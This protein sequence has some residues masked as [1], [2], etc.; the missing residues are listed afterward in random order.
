MVVVGQYGSNPGG[1]L[2]SA[3]GPAFDVMVAQPSTYTSVT[4][5][6]C[7]LGG[8]TT[9]EWWTGTAWQAISP[10]PNYVP[11]NPPCVTF[12]LTVASTPTLAQLTG[13]VFSGVDLEA[14]AVAL[15]QLPANPTNKNR[16]SIG[17]VA[18]DPDD[19]NTPQ[20]FC[21]FDG[22]PFTACSSPASPTSA[23]TDGNHTFS[24]H[25][26]D[27]S[28]NQSSD[29]TYNWLIDTAQPVVSYGSHQLVY[30]VDQN[31][32]IPCSVSD[33]PPSSGIA[34]SS[35]AAIA[36]PAYTFHLGLNNFTASA[37][38]KA[39]NTGTAS[40]SFTVTVTPGSLCSLTKQFAEGSPQFA[41]LPPATRST[42][43]SLTTTMCNLLATI[44]F[45]PAFK[46]L[47]VAAYQVL[48]KKLASNGWLTPSQAQILLTLAAAL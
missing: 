11:G 28:G 38:D 48:A 22:G 18:S 6:D 14:P 13:T 45:S 3:A 34:T 26:V 44:Q 32:N 27:S 9:V 39:G 21:S 2:K 15:S 37:T 46:P 35:C 12:T 47:A 10:A 31:I 43:D 42:I 29:V 5:K 4:V 1:L 25:A 40:I 19:A 24:V 36:G 8:G 16:P 20:T 7:N 23:L 33:P 17:L 41:K 30:T